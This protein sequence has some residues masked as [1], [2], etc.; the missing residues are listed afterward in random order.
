MIATPWQGSQLK[1][2]KRLDIPRA[3]DRK[4]PLPFGEGYRAVLVGQ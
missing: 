4:P 2:S 1:V 3:Q